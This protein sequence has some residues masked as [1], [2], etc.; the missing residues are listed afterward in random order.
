[1]FRIGSFGDFD[2]IYEGY[3]ED[4]VTLYNSFITGPYYGYGFQFLMGRTFAKV[5]DANIFTPQ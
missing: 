2:D 1:M 4:N 5:N 3:D